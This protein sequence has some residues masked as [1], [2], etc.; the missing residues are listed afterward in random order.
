MSNKTTKQERLDHANALIK[1]IA[2]HGRHFFFSLHTGKT[3]ELFIGK[4]GR[5]YLIDEYTSKV[6]F[7]HKTTWPNEWRGFSHGGTLRGM[8]EMMRDYI[9][10]VEKIPAFYL[11]I[12]RRN[13]TDGNVWG[14]SSEA[15]KAVRLEASM[16]PIIGD[17]N[18]Q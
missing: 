7:T 2:A 13:I 11:G 15:I 14:Y 12:D 9:V 6:I 4:Q 10:K 16:L 8:V 5:V 18:E 3:A 17:C 1:I